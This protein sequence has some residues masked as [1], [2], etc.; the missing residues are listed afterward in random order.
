MTQVARDAAGSTFS[1]WF[2]F[3]PSI[4][5]AFCVVSI[6]RSTREHRFGAVHLGIHVWGGDVGNDLDLV[7]ML[8]SNVFPYFFLTFL[9]LY[10]FSNYLSIIQLVKT[11]L[12]ES[13][14]S[15]LS[16]PCILHVLTS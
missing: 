7:A 8:Y 2:F 4:H 13:K 5:S 15:G 14:I 12:A 1:D 3:L 6:D 11:V 10:S 9:S 16:C